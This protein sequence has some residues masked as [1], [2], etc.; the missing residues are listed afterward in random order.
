MVIGCP[1]VSVLRL[2]VSEPKKGH[3]DVTQKVDGDCI[4]LLPILAHS[5]LVAVL[6]RQ[7]SIER[8]R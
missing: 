8:R 6:G 3:R 1:R 7:P 4:Y 5:S 2:L